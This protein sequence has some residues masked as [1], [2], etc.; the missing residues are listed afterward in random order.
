MKRLLIAATLVFSTV[1]TSF[2]LSCRPASVELSF[3]SYN[4]SKN[5]HIMVYGTLSNQRN[6]IQAP[7][8]GEFPSGR[9]FTATFDGMQGNRAGFQKALTT[10]V[11]IHETCI[12]TWCGAVGVDPQVNILAFFEV[13]PYGYRLDE[14][15]CQGA[16]FINPERK[17]IKN[18]LRCLRGGVCAP[19]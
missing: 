19:D 16:I 12:A 15:P 9:I 11:E 14:G 10:N 18:A 8:D 2:A 5:Q 13:T 1:T 3:Q 17:T 4:E 7:Q 6:I